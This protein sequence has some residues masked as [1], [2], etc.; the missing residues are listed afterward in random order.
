MD[1]NYWKN[2]YQSN[3]LIES[4]DSST[5]A[6]FCTD[7]YFTDRD[8]VICELGCGS[9]RDAIF[10]NNLGFKIIAIDQ[11]LDLFD[12]N[13][14]NNDLPNFEDILRHE[15]NFVTLNYNKFIDIDIFY[16]R[17]TLHS[18]KEHEETLI[19]RKVFD[20]LSHK[21]LFAVEARTIS[22]PLY[23]T[24]KHISDTTFMTD[25]KR[26][27]IDTS[28]FLKKALETGFKVKY[29]IEKNNLS[30]VGKDNPYLMRII[31]EK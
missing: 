12:S 10:F 24:G 22:D 1:R 31:L 21:G 3:S 17:F 4:I 6:K 2:Y 13:I 18:I 25:H 26:R 20:K 16:S 9:G 11:A 30:I 19:L 23:G 15:D 29:Y 28:K 27:F 7:C 14:R 8:M 5:F